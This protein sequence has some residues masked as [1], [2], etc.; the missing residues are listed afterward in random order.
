MNTKIKSDNSGLFIEIESGDRYHLA[1]RPYVGARGSVEEVRS[2]NGIT[3]FKEGDIVRWTRP[4]GTIAY[5][6]V[7]KQKTPEYYMKA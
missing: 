7:G 2:G 4:I 6:R 5:L 1:Q 3:E